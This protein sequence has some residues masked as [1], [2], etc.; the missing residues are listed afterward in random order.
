MDSD[1][2]LSPEA[3][4]RLDEAIAEYVQREELGQPI[5][6]DDLLRRYA[7]IREHLVT[8]FGARHTE[9]NGKLADAIPSC[10]PPSAEAVDVWELGLPYC[11]GGGATLAANHPMEVTP[12]ASGLPNGNGNALRIGDYELLEVIAHG[13]MGV[14]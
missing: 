7:D 10:S 4:R 12:A 1:R 13:G 3:Q 14:V 2:K 9:K 5:D 6:H 11:S 8:Y